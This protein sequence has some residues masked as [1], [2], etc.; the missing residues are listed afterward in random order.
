MPENMKDDGMP[1]PHLL[2]LSASAGSGKTEHLARRYIKY[3]L[4][5]SVPDNDMGNILAVTFTNNSAR[6]MKERILELVKKLALGLDPLLSR[7]ISGF[8]GSSP[9]ET[10]SRAGE[11]VENILLRYTDFN[12]RTIDSFIQSILSSSAL[13]LGMKPNPRLVL[14]YRELM[15]N[16]LALLFKEGG[17][18]ENLIA[19]Y[20]EALNASPGKNFLWDP[21][22]DFE[23]FMEYLLSRESKAMRPLVFQDR[24]EEM[25]E[26]FILIREAFRQIEKYKL[27][28]KGNL[29]KHLEDRDLTWM[30]ESRMQFPVKKGDLKDRDLKQMA[31]LLE[32]RWRDLEPVRLD[33][34][35]AYCHSKVA[36]YGALYGKFKE[37][38]EMARRKL[39]TMH[40]EDMNSMLAG[41]LS[42]ERVPEIY[43]KLG[44]RLCH[45]LVD[46]FQD[47]DPAQWKSLTPLLYESLAKKGSLFLVGDLKQA[48]YMFRRADY[49]I[50]RDLK[51]E[52]ECREPEE[53]R[54]LPPSVR[55]AAFEQSL[56]S[57]FRSGGVIVEYVRELFCERLPRWAEA[58]NFEDR[59]GLSSFL[60]ECLPGR[61]QEGY[62]RVMLLGGPG[63]AGEA[64]G[65]EPDESGEGGVEESEEGG[66]EPEKA[67]LLEILADLA[68][69]GFRPGD[70]AILTARNSE[71]EKVV[72]WLTESNIRS[73]ASGSLDIRK[74]RVVAEILELLRFLD[75]PID[76]LA[77]GKFILSRV[78]LSAAEKIMKPIS[79]SQILD[80]ISSR[81][82][83]EGRNDY[84]Y[85]CFRDNTELGVFWEE[86]FL[87]LFR[88]VG[89][90]PLYELVCLALRN[91]SVL[92]NFPS[93]AGAVLKFLE[94]IRSLEEAGKNNLGD[95]LTEVEEQEAEAF[96]VS[97]PEYLDAVH[98]LTFHK[99]KGL[100]FPVVINLIYGNRG[101]HGRGL[102]FL[103]EE[104]QLSAVYL[105]NALVKRI[106][107]ERPE[108]VRPYLESR[109]EELVQDLNLLYV[110]NTRAR[111]E[112]YNLVVL[113]EK[114]GA[115]WLTIFEE[116]EFGV[117][118]PCFPGTLRP[119]EA[120]LV[121]VL[122]SFQMPEEKGAPWSFLRQ[123]ESRM[124][125]LY[126]EVLRQ[127]EFLPEDVEPFLKEKLLNTAAAPGERERAG[128]KLKNF[129]LVPEAAE[130]F[131]EKDGRT[132]LTEAEFVDR[133]GSLYR[134]DRV[135]LD[136][137]AVTLVD[138]KA[139][140]EMREEHESQI[141]NYLKLLEGIYQ[142]RPVR[143]F[144]AYLETARVVEVCRL[145]EEDED[146]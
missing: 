44:E 114:R 14:R 95:F 117:R 10:A 42:E 74:R 13:E 26:A 45:F 40:I 92:D 70:I 48:V 77:F 1:F 68:S 113:P 21:A 56:D 133:Q 39:S 28:L 75:S 119:K 124:G 91:F 93:E 129:F 103:R 102:Y 9:E 12:V 127:I 110:I 37:C 4:S 83:P 41:F 96:D 89:Y 109:E 25:E 34:V 138:Y 16:A 47:T 116:G 23:E 107:N 118:T 71:M 90:L 104:D 85:T 46:E 6:E 141:E 30:A 29:K 2:L 76:D 100:G 62:V 135:V 142:G 125:D 50:M 63:H 5:S 145:G 86:L 82:I 43:F 3:V 51:L 57:N 97:L 122:D 88:K 120:P 22:R 67:R 66:E 146:E 7:E 144:L 58:N 87:E 79:R 139:G 73:T 64:D 59:S 105:N 17:P 32:A 132:I 8:L 49:R 84:L 53:D 72:G 81:N 131:R 94:M 140:S 65:E 61:E 18:H 126:H 55:D 31:A 121:P 143:A 112:L 111:N 128:K 38:M 134:V 137:G 69:R 24:R 99:C 136:T 108:L 130:L 52:I 20:L 78:F 101:R 33:L 19:G 36:F 60:Q 98:L 115:G 35:E 27:P 123:E 15:D 106:G 54:W 11:A 80:F